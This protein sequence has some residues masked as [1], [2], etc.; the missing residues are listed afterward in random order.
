MNQRCCYDYSMDGEDTSDLLHIAAM[1]GHRGCMEKLF[2]HESVSYSDFNEYRTTEDFL[3]AKTKS[4]VNVN[5][6][7]NGKDRF[8]FTPLHYAA[9]RGNLGCVVFLVSHLANVNEQ[10]DNLY[11][12]LHYAIVNGYVECAKYLIPYTD[13][14][15]KNID[16]DTLLHCAV[17]CGYFECVYLML[18]CCGG[19]T[20]INERNNKGQTPLHYASIRN[21]RNHGNEII[22][23]LLSRGADALAKD[24]DGKIFT[25]MIENKEAKT[26][27]L[28]YVKKYKLV[29]FDP[30]TDIF[31][32]ISI[33]VL[34]VL[35][36][37]IIAL[38]SRF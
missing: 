1:H 23:L 22:K 36:F 27:V 6:N 24:G 17:W 12:P 21:N 10:D 26:E 3:D 5:V 31:L 4:L 15:K 11:T 13:L 7:V 16:G 33:R 32:L 35:L 20:T 34:L 28:D 2:N 8:G 30:P 37:V 38:K 25:K 18:D 14:N 19:T 29:K 9:G